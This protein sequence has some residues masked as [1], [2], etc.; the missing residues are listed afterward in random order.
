MGLSANV[1][2]GMCVRMCVCA[3][4]R[5]CVRERQKYSIRECAGEKKSSCGRVILCLWV[6]AFVFAGVRV[7]ER[8]IELI[9]R[10]KAVS[11]P[12]KGRNRF[13]RVK[14]LNGETW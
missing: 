5:V 4:V 6:Y 11:W 13:V 14:A 9:I 10:L 2:V 7:C 8:K 12:Q 3:C 1:F